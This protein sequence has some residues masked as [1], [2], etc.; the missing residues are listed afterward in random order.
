MKGLI[1][2]VV[3]CLTAAAPV[4]AGVTGSFS[5]RGVQYLLKDAVA[6]EAKAESGG[7]TAIRVALSHVAIDPA[8]LADA[9]DPAG[10]VADARGEGPYVDLEF[11][12]D[13]AWHGI[14][15]LLGSGNGCG[16]CQDSQASAKSQVKLENGVLRGRLR[17]TKTDYSRG[18]GPAID[19]TFDLPVVQ[20]N[21]TPLPVDG[22]EP[23]KVLQACRS[24]AKAKD[25]VAARKS[26]FARKL[27][28]LE[29]YWNAEP[30]AF[31]FAALAYGRDSLKL[32]TLKIAGGRT[33]GDWAEVKVEGQD[34]Y[35][36]KKAGSVFLRKTP[37]GWRYH[38]EKLEA[39]F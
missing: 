34:E 33:K 38:H 12:R 29:D 26:C 2:T 4:Q 32:P 23:G 37:D 35:Q 17:I 10:V 16:W 1:A 5:N 30:D 15:Y 28:L 31:W 6:Y 8:A 9:I 11:G 3:V 21:A 36:Q 19:L 39:V 18:D 13:G 24:S 14:S 7:G 27:K 20:V 22:G 25:A